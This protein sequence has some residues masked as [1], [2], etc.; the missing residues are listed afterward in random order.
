MTI[1]KALHGFLGRPSDWIELFEG[2]SLQDNLQAEN[3]FS[4]EITDMCQWAEKFNAKEL[5]PHKKALLGYSLGGRLAL[6]ALFNKPEQWSSAV[7]IS[8]HLGMKILEKEYRREIDELWARRFE[9]DS[10]NELIVDWNNREVFKQDAFCFK[11]Y[12]KDYSRE[13]LAAALRK[14]SLSEQSELKQKV[15]EL[16]MPILWIAGADDLSYAKQALELRLCHPLSEIWI[17]PEAGH[18]VPW[19]HPEKFLLKITQ[20]LEMVYSS[21]TYKGSHS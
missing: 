19:Q 21:H 3:L 1:I 18:R 9:A 7:I 4:S 13:V 2:H 12:E 20:F 8:A 5:G 16:P 17:V 10:W 14:W 11:R 15:S 6:H